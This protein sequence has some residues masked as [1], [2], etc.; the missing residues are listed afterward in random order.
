MG[1]P[2]NNEAYIEQVRQAGLALFSPDNLRILNEKM[3]FDDYLALLSQCD[4]GYFIFARQQGIGTL[5]LLIQAGVPCVLNRLN[6]F[7]RDMVEE[8]VPVLFTDDML[9][10][11]VI[12]EAQRQLLAVDKD[13]IT[14]FSPNFIAPW[15]QALRIAAGE[16]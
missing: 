5:C 12:R 4:L 14:F 11:A 13:G 9:N 15:H 8:G 10:E 6:P 16:A 1:Y 2:A 7:W 3:A